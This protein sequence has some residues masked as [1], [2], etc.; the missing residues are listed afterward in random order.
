MPKLKRV[1][2]NQVI[3][4]L[5]SLAKNDAEKYQTFWK[6]FGSHLKQGV[7]TDLADC[8][9]AACFAPFQDQYPP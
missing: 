1:L 2:T 9:Q 6:E 8:R 5:E 7:A 3:K 4:E